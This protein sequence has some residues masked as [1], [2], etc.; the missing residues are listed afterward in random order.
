M[1]IHFFFI[2]VYIH[3]LKNCGLN[4][5]PRTLSVSIY[6]KFVSKILF[7]ILLTLRQRRNLLFLYRISD[8]NSSLFSFTTIILV[9]RGNS[10]HFCNSLV[11]KWVVFR[12]YYCN[13]KT[14][15]AIWQNVA[16]L[17]SLPTT[18]LHRYQFVFPW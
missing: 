3:V 8:Y 11:T 15:F 10:Y 2:I 13:L 12:L 14:I 17:F 1:L 16:P 4:I 18:V 9:I 5:N 7:A 6:Y